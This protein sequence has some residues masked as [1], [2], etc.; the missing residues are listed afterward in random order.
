MN[1]SLVEAMRSS[2]DFSHVINS[3]PLANLRDELDERRLIHCRLAHVDDV[4]EFLWLGWRISGTQA[5]LPYST[6]IC[7]AWLLIDYPIP[8]S[9]L[10]SVG[11]DV[12][13]PLNQA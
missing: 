3:I 2:T 7:L 10:P 8:I 5:K 9:E 13:V 11:K 1:I 6:Y 4:N 12:G